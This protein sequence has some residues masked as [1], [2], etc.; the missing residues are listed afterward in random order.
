M[1]VIYTRGQGFDGRFEDGEVG[2]PARYDNVDEIADR[3]I[4]ILDNYQEISKNCI[5]KVDRF[6]WGKI[7]MEYS[8]IYN[9]ILVK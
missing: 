3:I 2:Y 9:E 7:D 5:D 4:D 8:R 6:D 1:P